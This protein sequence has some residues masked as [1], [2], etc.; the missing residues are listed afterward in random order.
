VIA[1]ISVS[2]IAV[3][4]RSSASVKNDASADVDVLAAMG[5]FWTA[6]GVF[7][8]C[9]DQVAVQRSYSRSALCG[10]MMIFVMLN[11]VKYLNDVSW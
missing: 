11:G 1:G 9:S 5:W 10:S 2:Q 6:M 8:A 7:S 3:S 4:S